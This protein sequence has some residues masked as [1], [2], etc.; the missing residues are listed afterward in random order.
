MP[1]S[2]AGTQITFNDSSVQITAARGGYTAVTL[3]SA[4]PNAT[5]TTANNQL[6]MILND[7]TTPVFPSVTLPAMNTPLPQGAMYFEFTNTTPFVVALKDSAGTVREYIQPGANFELNIKD[8]GSATGQWFCNFPVTAAE[9][10]PRYTA[11]LTTTFKTTSSR[12]ASTAGVCALNSTSFAVI[13][14]EYSSLINTTAVTYARLYT[15][16]TSTKVFTAGN[17]VTVYTTSGNSNAPS[18]AFDSDNAGH[19]LVTIA[20]LSDGGQGFFAYNGLSVSGGTLYVGTAN[21][22]TGPAPAG[23]VVGAAVNIYTGYLGSNNAFGFAFL[24]GL[25]TG[26]N[27]FM[28]IRGCTVTGTTSVTITNSASNTSVTTNGSSGLTGW[29]ARTG[30]TTFV[31]GGNPSS[32]YGRAISYTPASNTLTVTTRSNQNR[33]DIEQGATAGLSSFAQGGFMYSTNKAFFGTSVFDI[34]NAGAAGVTAATSTG[35]NFKY[36]LSSNY[37]SFNGAGFSSATSRTSFYNGSSVIA[38]DSNTNRWQCDT[39]SSTL[40]LNLSNSY[41]V[42]NRSGFTYFYGLAST[43]FGML[44]GLTSGAATLPQTAISAPI[45]LATPITI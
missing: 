1:I 2:V 22:V 35:F 40:N 5:L 32:L 44:L 41:F 14:T 18:V 42:A 11:I 39:T 33:L 27:S 28:Y 16:N 13:W 7:A 25:D 10:D 17:T 36:N 3:T 30:L 38:V 8:N 45:S 9:A 6:I 19:A 21:V 20:W 43:S 4:A 34:T 23:C 31:C 15:L 29:G 26:L 24:L 37:T 12:T